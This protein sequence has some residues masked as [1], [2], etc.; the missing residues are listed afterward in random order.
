MIK[1]MIVIILLG[2]FGFHL[3]YADQILTTYRDDGNQTIFD[4]KWTFLQEWKRTSYNTSYGD[5][6]VVRTGHDHK[7]L[8]VLIDFTAQQKFSKHSDFGIVCIDSKDDRDNQPQKDDYCFIVTLGSRNPVTLQGG[9]SLEIN[10][11]Y[12]RISNDPNLVA[13]GGISDENDR[14]SPIPHTTYEFKIPVEI[15]GASDRYGFFAG[16]YVANENK[17]HSWP[18]DIKDDTIF[19]IPSD[20]YWGEMI[21]PDKSLPEFPWPALALVSSVGLII[22]LT[23][24]RANLF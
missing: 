9:S 19:H 21:S 17:M 13:V 24:F 4:G 18:Q 2:V 11:H 7:N 22:Y 10:N 8:Y 5:T 12:I 23:R 3:V 14:Y 1:G 16:A 20:L 15:F 6:F